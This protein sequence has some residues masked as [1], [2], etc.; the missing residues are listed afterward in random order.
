MCQDTLASA[1][2]LP[3][4]PPH[5]GAHSPRDCPPPRALPSS[6][7]QMVNRSA[8]QPYPVQP[9]HSAPGQEPHLILVPRWGGS[10]KAAWGVS[11]AP[12][13][14]GSPA[15]DLPRGPGWMGRGSACGNPWLAPC[16][17]RGS[18]GGQGLLPSWANSLQ[19]TQSCS[20][21]CEV[22][23]STP[24]M[25]RDHRHTVP[26]PG[27]RVLMEHRRRPWR[28]RPAHP[29]SQGLHCA[30]DASCQPTEQALL[31]DCASGSPGV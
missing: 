8:P 12:P 19:A 26:S 11:W 2:D 29:R 30:Q 6:H 20:P 16:G 4:L 21:L 17:E 3:Q 27:P 23:T 25:S 7:T 13:S 15:R 18:T 28:A 14:S 5:S 22:G 1:Q 31:W 24:V 10:E 9:P